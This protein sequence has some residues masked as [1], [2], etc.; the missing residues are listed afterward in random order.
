MA[1]I[2]I[3]E[4][5]NS[6]KSSNLISV[7]VQFIC[8]VCKSNKE[9]KISKSVVNQ[10]KSLTTVSIPSGLICEHSFQA[11]ID[12]QFKVRGYQKVDFEFNGNNEVHRYST[13]NIVNYDEELFKNLSMKRNTL[14]YNPNISRKSKTTSQEKKE[15]HPLK[16]EMSLKEIYEEF[17]EFIDDDN[18]VFREFIINDP[19]R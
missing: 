3:K 10:A 15:R 4:N 2:N 1:I 5:T 14:I 16:K 8:P 17:W 7:S 9:L 19:R 6:N 12:K 13:Q 11:F 18:I